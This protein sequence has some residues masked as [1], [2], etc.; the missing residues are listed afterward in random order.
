MV[1][2]IYDMSRG[3]MNMQLDMPKVTRRARKVYNRNHGTISWCDAPAIVFS[4][5][6]DGVEFYRY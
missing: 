3:T 2:E 4:N 6:L 5:L 1:E